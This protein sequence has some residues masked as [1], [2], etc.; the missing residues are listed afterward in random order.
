MRVTTFAAIAVLVLAVAGTAHAARFQVQPTRVELAGEHHVG[1]VTITNRSD[2]AV[3]FQVTA[4]TWAEDEDGVTK[5][6]PTD[7]LVVYPTLFTVDAGGS[8]GVRVASM[9]LPGAR[10]VPYRIFVQELPA[11]RSA[12]AAGDGR[13]TMLTRM[14]IPVFLPPDVSR[15]AGDVAADL[16]GDALTI[17]LR[18]RGSVHVRVATIRVVG[19]GAGG[20]V[21]DR[22]QP[23]WYL[24]AGGARR[25][26]LRFT[27]DECRQVTALRVEVATDRGTWQ[28]ARQV[29]PG[30]R[31]T[32]P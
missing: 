2:V 8:R 23:G 4:M 21:F 3:R 18:N 29:A 9:A 14:G 17:R 25:Y 10:E 16:A 6:V 30:C 13:I 22:T 7:D 1:S 27:A 26:P 5:L 15:V 12:D 19:E 20:V 32:A 28:T 24:L 31:T 11:L